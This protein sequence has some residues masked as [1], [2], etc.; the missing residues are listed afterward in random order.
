MQLE[1]NWNT[2]K[3]YTFLSTTSHFHMKEIE[4]FW[5]KQFKT[6]PSTR[7]FIAVGSNNINLQA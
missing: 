4:L 2:L 7:C 1:V 3:S 5:Q 6:M